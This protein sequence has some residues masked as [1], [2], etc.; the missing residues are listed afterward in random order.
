MALTK[1]Y[2]YYL[3]Q[4]A[5]TKSRTGFRRRRHLHRRARASSRAAAADRHLDRGGRAV[6]RQHL[7][8]GLGLP[9]HRGRALGLHLD[10]RRHDL[11]RGHPEVPGAAERAHQGTAVHRAQHRGDARRVRSR[12]TSRPRRSTTTRRSTRPRPPPRSRPSTTPVS[13]TRCRRRTRSRCTQEITPF[14]SFTDVDVDRYK[15]G[16]DELASRCSRRCAS[17]TSRTSPTTRGRASTSSTRTGTARS[18]RP[19]TRSTPTSRATCCRGSRPPVSCRARST[20][21]TPAC[22]SARASAGTRSS[23]SKVAEQEATSGGA[24]KATTYQGTAGRQGVELRAQGRARAALRRLEPA[25]LRAGDRT[26]R[27]SSTS[28]T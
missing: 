12:R 24:T 4:F 23:T 2:Q 21:V 25:R 13:T 8:P 3:A 22:T 7:A 27:A 16:E 19:R 5:L 18:R 9:D 28:A 17:S 10:R 6:H 26:T 15:I 14:Y 1:T 20:P 11:P